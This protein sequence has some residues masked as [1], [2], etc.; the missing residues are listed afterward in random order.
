MMIFGSL[1][2]VT[3]PILMVAGIV[4]MAARAWVEQNTYYLRGNGN[5]R[6]REKRSE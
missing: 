3:L 2:Y 5:E 6:D 1:L 4:G